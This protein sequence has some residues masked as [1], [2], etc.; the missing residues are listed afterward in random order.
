MGV[1]EETLK[2]LNPELRTAITPTTTYDLK[3]PQ[4]KKPLLLAKLHTVPVTNPEKPKNKYAYHKVRRGQNISAIARRYG[5]SIRT[6]ARANNLNRRYT[7]RTGQTLKIPLSKN[8]YVAQ[9]TSTKKTYKPITHRVRKG[10]SL[11]NLAKRY[12]TTTRTIQRANKMRGTTLKI[13]QRL[14]IPGGKA[15][16]LASSKKSKTKVY[17]VRKGD[18]P[19]AIAL[20]NGMTLTRFLKLNKMSKRSKIFPGQKVYVE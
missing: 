7:I 8:G 19:F 5:A 20:K 17:R 4:D 3:V 12:G 14:S 2:M 13:G 15:T 16:Q 6:L 10:D 9:A 18:S 1:S 11:W